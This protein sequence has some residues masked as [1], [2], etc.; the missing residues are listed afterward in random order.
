[1]ALG[2]EKGY[3]M[4]LPSYLTSV[5]L[6]LL[7]L[8]AGVL[9]PGPSFVMAAR[10][11]VAR[12]RADGL[13]LALG[14]ALGATLIAAMCLAGLSA[15][16]HAVPALYVLL[17]V[18]GGLYLAWLAWQIWK[19]APQPLDMTGLDQASAGQIKK[20]RIASFRLGVITQISNPKAAV[21]YGSV[22][23]ALLPAEFPLMGSL[24]VAAG[25]FVM[26]FGWMSTVVLVLSSSAP[27]AA[28]M[29][30]KT[31]IDRAAAGVMGLLAAR[32]ISTANQAH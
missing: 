4:E 31:A 19:S 7:A 29:R 22:F 10:T 21:V 26:E 23:A 27:L 9:S 17:K 20:Q 5:G 3:T 11:A 2:L 25:V 15:V 6:I 13:A 12:S 14:L 8:L 1:M 30:G 24:L 28:Y 16:L 18:L 32:L